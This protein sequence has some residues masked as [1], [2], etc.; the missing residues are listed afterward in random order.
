MPTVTQLI[1]QIADETGLSS[2]V[3]E[4]VILRALNRAL[5]RIHAEHVAIGAEPYVTTYVPAATRVYSLSPTLSRIR[6]FLLVDSSTGNA[7][8]EIMPLSY[9]D[10]KSLAASQLEHYAVRGNNIFFDGPVTD[11]LEG[12]LF[13][14]AVPAPLNAGTA[15][16]GIEVPVLFHEDLLAVIAM[17]YILEG[18][19]GDEERAAYYR[20]LAGE[21][22]HRYKAYMR[23][24]TGP[25]MPNWR[26][27]A[28][29]FHTPRPLGSR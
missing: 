22:M 20:Q 3:Q 13:Y 29:H 25:N 27:G 2:T 4:A 14:D 28:P 23:T 18:Y 16:A 21:A 24:R 26:H 19:E 7:V 10:V 12:K 17:T 15:E 11:G 9:A 6:V 1:S 5:R 8:R